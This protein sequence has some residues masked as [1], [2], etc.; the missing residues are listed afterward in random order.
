MGP[1]R[2]IRSHSDVHDAGWNPDGCTHP[3]T[4]GLPPDSVCE[5]E[6]DVLKDMER[7]IHEFHDNEKC[8]WRIQ[9]CTRDALYLQCMILSWRSRAA[10][11]KHQCDGQRCGHAKGAGRPTRRRYAM[12]RISLAPCSPFTVNEELMVRPC[13]PCCPQ[14]LHAPNGP[15]SLC[16]IQRH[17]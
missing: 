11:A 2:W 13:R 14:V 10:G 7:L 5:E 16:P 17:Q 9:P 4:G 15:R 1:N 6:P 12:L 3:L 8:A